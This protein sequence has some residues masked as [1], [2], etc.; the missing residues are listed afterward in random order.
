MKL[1]ACEASL[2]AHVEAGRILP[3]EVPQL[4]ALLAS[5]PDDDDGMIEFASDDGDVRKKPADILEALFAALPVRVGYD[6]LA[7]GRQPPSKRTQEQPSATDNAAIAAEAQALMSEAAD[8]GVTLT[9]AQAVD[10]VRAKR[11]LDRES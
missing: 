5:L 3:A 6:E 11:G 4:S 1:A 7:G 10:Q 9:T 8:R 2:K